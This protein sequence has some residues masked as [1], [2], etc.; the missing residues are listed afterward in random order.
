MKKS[1]IVT[2]RLNEIRI[3]GGERISILSEP[4]MIWNN[5]EWYTHQHVQYNHYN[6]YKS[7]IRQKTDIQTHKQA[8]GQEQTHKV[9]NLS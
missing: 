1:S 7:T 4:L 2:A 6:P 9:K 5:G 3:T 8:D